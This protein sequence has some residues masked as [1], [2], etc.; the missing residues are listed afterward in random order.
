GAVLEGRHFKTAEAYKH[1]V[2][3]LLTRYRQDVLPQK[4][5]LTI[6]TQAIHLRYWEQHLG[7]YPLADVTPVMIVECR[8]SLARTRSNTTA[9]RYLAV[10]SHAFTLAV[11]EWGWIDDTPLRKVSRPKEPRGRVRFLSDEERRCLLQA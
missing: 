6:R 3:E 8:D 9:V 4:R 5:P 7:R 10:L 11:K 2:A 1:T